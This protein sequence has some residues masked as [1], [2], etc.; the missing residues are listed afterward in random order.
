MNELINI[1]ALVGLHLCIVTIN[2]F[3]NVMFIAQ[4]QQLIEL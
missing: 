4:K 3:W 1:L 2:I